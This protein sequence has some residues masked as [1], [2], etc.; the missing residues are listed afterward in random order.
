MATIIQNGQVVQTRT[1]TTDLTTFIER[2]QT[3][4]SDLQQQLKITT[5]RL[6][7]VLVELESLLPKEN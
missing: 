2:K 7:E 1:T 6:N 5:D 4:V 3:E